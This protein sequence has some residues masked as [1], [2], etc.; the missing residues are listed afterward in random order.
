[1]VCPNCSHP[2]EPGQKFCPNCGFQLINQEA[3]KRT[4]HNIANENENNVFLNYAKNNFVLLTLLI[5][6][7]CL[8]FWW[9]ILF[10]GIFLALII[11]IYYLRATAING[12]QEKIEKKL[13]NLNNSRKNKNSATANEEVTG[14]KIKF[15]KPSNLVILLI[16][17]LVTIAS[18]FVGNFIRIDAQ[19][20]NYNT[21]T[22]LSLYDALNLGGVATKLSNAFGV[23]IDI[24]GV[25]LIAFYILV[26]IPI[27]VIVLTFLGGRF[28][29]TL[30]S[31]ISFI[32]Y[33]GALI[34]IYY[35][36]SKLKLVGYNLGLTPGVM[37]FVIIIS[38]FVMTIYSS[39]VK[40]AD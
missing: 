12:N 17:T 31:F 35:E 15:S 8:L 40:K 36:T 10:G 34:F 22:P 9:K 18:S 28:L 27:L 30:L 33:T 16:S 13:R 1:M 21:S 39:R 20:T 2:I 14:R 4:Q 6:I 25:L 23:Q 11:L 32:V 24:Q 38:T 37:F 7:D 3:R 29:R 26:L 19:T 5:L